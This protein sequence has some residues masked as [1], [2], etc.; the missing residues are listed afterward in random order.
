MQGS[1]ATSAVPGTRFTEIRWVPETGSTNAD[2]LAAAAAGAAEGLVL[3]ADHQTAGRGRLDRSWVAPPGSSL[4]VSVLLRPTIAPDALFLL[5]AAAGVAS[6]EAA[7]TVAGVRVGLKW[8]NDLVAVGPPLAD[9]KLSGVLAESSVTDGEVRAVVV[10]MGLNVNWPAELPEDLAATATSLDHLAGHPV[11][12]EALL[13]A[14]LRRLDHWIGAIEAGPDGR[15]SL[16]DQLR[17]RSATLGRAV[18]VELASGVV[19]GEAV[20]IDEDGHLQVATAG[21]A[22][23]LVVAVGDIVHLRPVS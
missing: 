15:R 13:V 17:E 18:R 9:R 23:P 1:F 7:E 4:L 10:G 21:S 12:R 8:P 3:V 11:D 22:E 16:V 5:T 20:A 6:A 2:L 14:W 19:E